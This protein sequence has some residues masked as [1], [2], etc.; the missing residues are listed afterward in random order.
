MNRIERKRLCRSVDLPRGRGL[1]IEL[2]DG[3]PI[4]IF[5]VG[6]IIRAVG[7]ICPH[8]KADKLHDGFIEGTVIRCPEHGWQFDLETGNCIGQGGRL[9]TYRVEELDGILWLID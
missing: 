3:S 8:Q 5:R 2:D 6:D 9:P 1:R 7:N 4:A